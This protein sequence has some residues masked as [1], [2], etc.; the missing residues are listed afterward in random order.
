MADS[1]PMALPST[2]TEFLP[3]EHL[4]VQASSIQAMQASTNPAMR[5]AMEASAL[6]SAAAGKLRAETQQ[7]RMRELEELQ[8]SMGHTGLR[9]AW[10]QS[11]ELADKRA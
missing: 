3:I 7:Q 4:L 1:W 5:Q 9:A 8:H 2:F 11:K 6:M 10:Q